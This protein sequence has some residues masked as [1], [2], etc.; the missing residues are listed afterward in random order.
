LSLNSSLSSFGDEQILLQITATV[1]E[2]D[3]FVFE[4]ELL[5]VVWQDDAAGR[6]FALRVQY[7]M[8]RCALG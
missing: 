1:F 3:A 8:P 5:F 2:D 4:H 6:G 7:A